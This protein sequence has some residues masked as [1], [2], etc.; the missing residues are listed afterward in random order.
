MDFVTE[1]PLL[2]NSQKLSDDPT[3]KKKKK[4]REKNHQVKAQPTNTTRALTD[5]NRDV[6]NIRFVVLLFYCSIVYCVCCTTNQSKRWKRE[7]K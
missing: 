4:K 3:K 1:S 7:G 5:V 2:Q 6:Q